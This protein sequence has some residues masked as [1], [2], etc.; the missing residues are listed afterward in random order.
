MA[1]HDAAEDTK[2]ARACSTALLVDAHTMVDHRSLG[3]G[4]PFC[5]AS[6]SLKWVGQQVHVVKAC[7]QDQRRGFP[8]PN[9]KQESKP[10]MHM[11]GQWGISRSAHTYT[12][13]VCMFTKAREP[14]LQLLSKSR[15]V[16]S[17]NKRFQPTTDKSQ[18]KSSW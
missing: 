14:L 2:V 9:K 3:Y 13:P 17:R 6:P 11:D 1:T 4:H 10:R 7:L 15:A 18:G 8:M 5:L 16:H 12:W